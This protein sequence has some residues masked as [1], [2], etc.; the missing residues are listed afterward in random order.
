MIKKITTLLMILS[1]VITASAQY[2]TPGKGEVYSLDDLVLLSDDVVSFEDGAYLISEDLEISAL[3][4]LKI[5]QNGKL[6][7]AP[8]I[9]IT[10]AGVLDIN[11]P[12]EFILDCSEEE[13]KFKGI[14]VEQDANIFLNYTVM[15][16]GGGI[17]ILT[18]LK[19]VITHSEF[20]DNYGGVATGGVINIS[21][22]S[23]IIEGNIFKENETPAIGT[24]GNAGASA[25]LY[26]AN[27]H[28]EAN[29]LSNSNRPQINI[30]PTGTENDTIKIINNTIIG[31]RGAT[32]AGAI[33]VSALIGGNVRAIIQDNI[34]RDNRY[35][36]T[37]AGTNVWAEIKANII[38]DNDTEGDPMLGGSGV[39]LLTQNPD[40]YDVILTENQFRRNL[41]GVTLQYDAEANLGDDINNPGNNV[42]SEN[43]NNGEIFAL[44]NNTSSTI[45][46]KHNCWI[47]NEDITLEDAEEV[48]YHQN[49]DDS[50][51]EVIFDPV[52][53][54]ILGVEDST[55]SD[56]KIAPNPARNFIVLQ[57]VEL[58]DQA[59][60]YDVKGKE[61]GRYVI[62]ENSEQ[63]NFDL[64]TG[65]YFIRLQNSQQQTTKK[66]VVR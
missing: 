9:Q 26:I 61:V 24:A 47:E 60:I 43:G 13:S 42:F 66:L 28:I 2:S 6:L 45:M 17:R 33:A 10:V 50:L 22:G 53:C 57:G 8:E 59:M 11:A 23:H 41:W 1:A 21:R 44:Y 54:A 7:L 32:R 65:V 34:I 62:R 52:S 35:G 40:E 12:D 16:N 56:V 19:S 31:D 58:F 4:T 38:E 3:D 27:N 46:A 36:I 14:R 5:H 49:D 18:G 20:R 39:N 55:L 15:R 37:I 29:N 30:G 25:A 63:I 64:K 48:I 51:G